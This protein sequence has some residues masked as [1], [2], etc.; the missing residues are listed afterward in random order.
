MT[1]AL[2]ILQL[3]FGVPF[4]RDGEEYDCCGQYRKGRQGA[5]EEAIKTDVCKVAFNVA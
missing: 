5:L 1:T 2:R 3:A 4:G